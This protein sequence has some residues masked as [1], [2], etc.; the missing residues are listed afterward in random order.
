MKA[1]SNYNET[2]VF[3]ET[4]K[5]LSGGYIAKI[6]AAE[7]KTYN[8]QNGSFEKLEISFDIDEGDFKDYYA[9]QYRSNPNADKKWKGKIS[10]YVP[11]DDGSDKDA[12]TKRR[13]KTAIDAIEQSNS[14]YRWDWDEKKL[15]GKKCGVVLQNKEWE[16]NGKTGWSAV[17]YSITSVESIRN[18]TF[19]MPKDK[20]LQYNSGGYT[21]AAA[22]PANR[23]DFVE[24]GNDDDS[25]PF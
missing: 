1:F 22:T 13:F 7:V 19:Y 3:T 23:M 17:P 18:N 21:T 12:I 6:M 2:Q 11:T 5:I 16:Y 20:P 8:G 4:Q 9:D 10:L 14:G 24:V 25:L 15:K